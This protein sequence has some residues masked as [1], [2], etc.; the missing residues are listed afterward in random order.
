M[1]FQKNDVRIN[2]KGRLKKGTAL[3]DILNY[4]LDQKNEAGK[5]R[6]EVIAEKLIGLAEDGDFQALRYLTDRI[7]GKPRES[8]DA[9]IF[10]AM[11]TGN[12]EAVEN[13]LMEMLNLDH[14][15]TDA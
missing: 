14:N 5:L 2:R 11:A 7:D 3:T 13:K 9:T 12:I 4:K 10:G 1:L 6:R 15:S 8:V